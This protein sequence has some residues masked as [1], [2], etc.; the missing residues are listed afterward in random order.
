MNV[1]KLIAIPVSLVA[2]G[3]GIGPFLPSLWPSCDARSPDTMKVGVV[4]I[5]PLLDA[6]WRRMLASND[7]DPKFQAFQAKAMQSKLDVNKI[8]HS[9]ELENLKAEY[10]GS[11][12]KWHEQRQMEIKHAIKIIAERQG[13]HLVYCNEFDVVPWPDTQKNLTQYKDC[14]WSPI[15]LLPAVDLTRDVM[16]TM[17]EEA[18]GKK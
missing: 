16:E 7:P 3:A 8:R 13:F 15:N 4:K 9:N 11:L 10:A 2:L 12:E 6:H 14:R 18:G 17:K 1:V 5:A